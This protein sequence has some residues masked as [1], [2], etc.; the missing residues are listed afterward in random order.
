MTDLINNDGMPVTFLPRPAKRDDVPEIPGAELRTLEN[1]AEL[2]YETCASWS[3]IAGDNPGPHW[4]QLDET[5]KQGIIDGVR[6][7]VEK[8]FTSIADQHDNWRAW[9]AGRGWTHGDTKTEPAK[10]H[11]NMVPFD[12]LPWA[13]QRKA[14]LFRHV[15]HAIIG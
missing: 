15:I 9:M 1:L 6:F 8:P 7:V 14:N 2:A 12:E 11:P 3:L 10:T 13:Q 4:E 5:Q